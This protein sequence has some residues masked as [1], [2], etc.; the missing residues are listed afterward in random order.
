MKVAFKYGKSNDL[1][2]D[3]QNVYLRVY[4]SKFEFLRSLDLE[5]S[6]KHWNK[7][8]SMINLE[9]AFDSFEE[10]QYYSDVYK[11]LDHITST[12]RVEWFKEKSKL[13][14]KTYNQHQFKTWCENTLRRATGDAPEDRFLLTDKMQEYAELSRLGT[15]TESTYQNWQSKIR[16]LK[17]FEEETG[18]KYYFDEVGLVWWQELM[19]WILASG[20]TDTYHGTITGMVR[21][22]INHFGKEL[23]LKYNREVDSKKF[24]VIKKRKKHD[25]LTKEQMELIHSYKGKA[26]LEN[27][28]DL[29]I[30]QFHACLRFSELESELKKGS[31]DIEEHNGKYYWSIGVRKTKNWKEVELNPR[32]K[33]M[34]DTGTL[35]HLISYK[36]YN[37]YIK[38]LCSELG[39]DMKISTHTLRRS[40]CTHQWNAGAPPQD[41]MKYSG[42]TSEKSLR[43]YINKENENRRSSVEHF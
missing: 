28:R 31:F 34:I 21:A 5:V 4:H 43:V 25:V 41:I 3:F 22:T 8:N 13:K 18:K 7:K 12:F 40:F 17:R 24:V 16:T 9:S 26:Y 20:N 1:K 23:G 15:G 39:I 42:H 29:A 14:S 27:V 37:R 11:Q 38:E 35:P 36:N 6:Q 30:I 2:K 33:Q 19:K 32:I 10:R